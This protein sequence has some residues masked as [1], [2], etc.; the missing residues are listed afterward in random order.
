MFPSV[1]LRVAWWTDSLPGLTW[2]CVESPHS[3]FLVLCLL[4][5]SAAPSE[6]YPFVFF[7]L[8]NLSNIKSKLA[9]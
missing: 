5:S 6:L 2:L 4:V 8:Q 7:L 1:A 3:T 9:E